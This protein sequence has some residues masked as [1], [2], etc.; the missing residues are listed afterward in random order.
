MTI[1]VI[2]NMRNNTDVI[3]KT[4]RPNENKSRS[5]GNSILFSVPSWTKSD[6]D[7]IEHRK[8][9]NFFH[10]DK[11]Y[12]VICK[13]ILKAWNFIETTHCFRYMQSTFPFTST[14]T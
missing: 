14:L 4:P 13:G 11:L 6:V 5:V 8:L 3:A 7:T 12:L 1:R 2:K 9:I 10:A